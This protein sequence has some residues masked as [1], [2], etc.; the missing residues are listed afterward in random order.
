LAAVALGLLVLVVR[1]MPER[2]SAGAPAAK[3]PGWDLPVRAAVATLL[4][5]GLTGAAPLLGPLASG[6][7]SGFPLYA[8]VLT[9]FAHRT[10]G[11]CA[12]ASV[13]RGLAVGLFGFGS[14]FLVIA[15]AL[16]PLGAVPAFSLATLAVLAAQAASLVW[17][18]RSLPR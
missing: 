10:D 8:T 7:V 15:F 12:A 3:L 1:L 4:V 9:V 2:R 16:I 14:F 6:I 17:L 13:M 5:I 11:P 18:R